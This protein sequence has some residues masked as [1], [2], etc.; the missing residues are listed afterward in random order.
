R[1]DEP[2]KRRCRQFDREHAGVDARE[3]EEVVD[4]RAEPSRLLPQLLDVLIGGRDPVL[5]RLDHRPDGGERRAPVVACPGAEL[6]AG[7]RA[8]IPLK[9][10]PSSAI[11]VGPCSGARA[12]RSPPASA[13]D[14]ARSRST[15]AVIDLPTSSAAAIAT[16]E[17]AAATARMTTSAPMW[18]IATPDR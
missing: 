17:E 2:V 13:P 18:N 3:L 1:I 10:A 6:A 8:A 12:E 16:V 14:T 9:A 11:S 5:D 7:G 15:G 4:E